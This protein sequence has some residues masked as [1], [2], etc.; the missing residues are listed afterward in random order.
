MAHN[1]TKCPVITRCDQLWP[2]LTQHSEFWSIFDKCAWKGYVWLMTPDSGIYFIIGIYWFRMTCCV[3]VQ[4][5]ST[6]SSLNVLVLFMSELRDLCLVYQVIACT[7][8][9][10]KTGQFSSKVAYNRPVFVTVSRFDRLGPYLSLYYIFRALLA[11]SVR[12]D[13][14]KVEVQGKRESGQKLI[15]IIQNVMS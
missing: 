13:L 8:L 6:I 4:L 12:F 5:W 7:A 11:P 14:I 10:D 2:H 15:I 3:G 9:W 1:H